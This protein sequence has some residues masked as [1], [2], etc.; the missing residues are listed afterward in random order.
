MWKVSRPEG[1]VVSIPSVTDRKP[2]WRCSSSA[3]VSTRCLS[4][5]AKRVEAPDDEWV[6]SVA[7]VF[8]ASLELWTL[9]QGSGGGVGEALLA[10]VVRVRA[11]HALATP[12]P[13]LY[14]REKAEDSAA[15]HRLHR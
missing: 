7:Q 12:S 3:I 2:I 10:A 9:A 11:Q 15:V 6:L 1:V 13:A 4:V 14:D 5:P 8:E